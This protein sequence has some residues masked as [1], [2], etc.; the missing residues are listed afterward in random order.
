[1]EGKNILA[2]SGVRRPK[3]Q[4]AIDFMISYGI[5]LLVLAIVIYVVASQ[6]FLANTYQTSQCSTTSHMFNCIAYMIKANGSVY[7]MFQSEL[8]GYITITGVACSTQTNS[9]GSGPRY[10][11]VDVLSP[12]SANGVQY[13]PSNAVTIIAYGGQKVLLRAYCYGGASA[14]PVSG[15]LGQPFTGYVWIN[16]T[17]SQLPSSF[18]QTEEALSFTSRR[19]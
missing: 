15:A 19:E 7:I 5:A 11:N 6:G 12:Y 3:A 16:Y 10:G 8:P 4:S 17:Y 13:Y 14:A 2:V 18:S 1:M 9:T